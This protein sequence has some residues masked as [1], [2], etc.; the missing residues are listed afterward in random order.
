MNGQVKVTRINEEPGIDERGRVLPMMKVE[1][2]VGDH[3]P[4][5]YRCRKD[6]FNPRT[7]RAELDTWAQQLGTLTQ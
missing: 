2:M 5:V 7:V 6:Q 1:Y 3:G 4:F